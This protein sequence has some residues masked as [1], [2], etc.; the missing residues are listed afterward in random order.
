[1]ADWKPWLLAARPKTLPA[2]VVPVWLGSVLA[3]M[4]DQAFSPWLTACTL[5]SA[6]AIQVATNLFNDAI[7][8][9]KGA[10][11]EKRLGP[12]RITAS[13][14]ASPRSVVVAGAAAL[15]V[16]VGL[17]FP[18]VLARGWPI[19]AI[20]LPSLY[21]SF[22]YTGGPVPLAY[23]GLGELFVILFF[24]LVAVAG[25][26]FVQTGRW[27]VESAMLGL[28]VGAL[29]T[30]LIAVNNLRDIE[31]D[32][33]SG[34]RTLAAR[35]GLRF[36]RVE[37]ATLMLAPHALGVFW[38]TSGRPMLFL[39]PLLA[40]PLA[41]HLIFQVS[42]FPPGPV[43]NRVLALSGAQLILFGALFTAA[44]LAFM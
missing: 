20:G 2:A 5:G 11:T 23:R 9:G 31:E 29:S 18:L 15:V 16:A 44:A 1:M 42:R 14:M 36:G 38:V 28:Q 33:R 37:I 35:F 39:L 8:F 43:Y 4:L 17:A 26:F 13:G 30:A 12:V 10:D 19:L 3:W 25:T 6:V 41:L 24:G 21:F 34:K 40:A 22:G 27:G 32:R 7:D